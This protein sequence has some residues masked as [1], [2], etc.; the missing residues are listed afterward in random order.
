[1]VKDLVEI[2]P[3]RISEPVNDQRIIKSVDIMCYHHLSS[4]AAPFS[5]I[6]LVKA[7]HQVDTMISPGSPMVTMTMWPLELPLSCLTDMARQL[8]RPSA[9]LR[10]LVGWARSSLSRSTGSDS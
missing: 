3:N 10:V 5:I 9:T 2:L 4:E 1:M 6:C 8:T 7:A